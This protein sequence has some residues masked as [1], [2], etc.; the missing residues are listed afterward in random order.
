MKCDIELLFTVFSE[1]GKTFPEYPTKMVVKI[2]SPLD[3]I[4]HDQFAGRF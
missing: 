3:N 4:N 1:N 2:H